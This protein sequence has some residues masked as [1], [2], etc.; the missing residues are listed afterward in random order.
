MRQ[1]PGN[2][3]G[4][5]V[6]AA[7]AILLIGRADSPR[8]GTAAGHGQWTTRASRCHLPF[9]HCWFPGRAGQLGRSAPRQEA[10]CPRRSPE[11]PGLHAPSHRTSWL[12]EQSAQPR[13]GP[14]SNG[15]AGARCTQSGLHEVFRRYGPF[16][17]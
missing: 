3:S 7:A 15:A 6:F 14:T 4:Y 1:Q 17:A 16:E 13:S 2:A 8:V 11:S 12:P 5:L 10:R 9:R